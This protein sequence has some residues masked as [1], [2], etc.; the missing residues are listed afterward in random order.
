MVVPWLSGAVI[1]GGP[2]NYADAEDA[3]G[4]SKLSYNRTGHDG[5]A[6]NP[7]GKLVASIFVCIPQR[8]LQSPD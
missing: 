4:P 7:K 5:Q 2:H 8:F 1:A 3:A 6:S